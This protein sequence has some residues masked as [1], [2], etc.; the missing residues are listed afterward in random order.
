[1]AFVLLATAER[2]TTATTLG[3]L[4]FTWVGPA[5]LALA[6]VRYGWRADLLSRPAFYTM[7]ALYIILLP[8]GTWL[9]TSDETFYWLGDGP[10]AGYWIVIAIFPI[11]MYPLLVDGQRRETSREDLGLSPHWLLILI[12]PATW[13]VFHLIGE[14]YGEEEGGRS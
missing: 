9:G 3:Q 6:T 10:C 13:L 11:M 5:L 14:R 7:A 2:F 8:V 12:S 1:M 4:A